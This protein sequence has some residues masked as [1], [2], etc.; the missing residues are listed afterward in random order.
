M[1]ML[2]LMVTAYSAFKSL[3]DVIAYAKQNSG[4]LAY[5]FSG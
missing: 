2:M 5:G 1:L 4:K 3:A